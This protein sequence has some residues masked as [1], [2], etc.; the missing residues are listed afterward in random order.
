MN[1]I[2]NLIKVTE[3]Q[4]ELSY[5]KGQTLTDRHLSL[6]LRLDFLLNEFEKELYNN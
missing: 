5:S 4:K 2:L 1:R 6:Q 3:S